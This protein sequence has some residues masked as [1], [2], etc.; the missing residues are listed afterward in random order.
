[1]PA[2]TTRPLAATAPVMP[3]ASANGNGQAVGHAEDEV[4]DRLGAGAVAFAVV[5]GL[6]HR[7]SLPE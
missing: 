3:A 1:M 4:A 2:V 5:E 6:N 7:R